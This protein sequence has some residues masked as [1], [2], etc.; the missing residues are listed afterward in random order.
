MEELKSEIKLEM[1]ENKA[2]PDRVYGFMLRII[3][4][5]SLQEPAPKE[6]EPEPVAEE[7]EPVAEEPKEPEPVAEE[8]H[9]EEEEDE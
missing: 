8:T 2:R 1:R 7:P 9:E 3:E 5:L 4:Q 6:P